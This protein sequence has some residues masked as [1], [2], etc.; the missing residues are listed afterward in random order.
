MVVL[1]PIV[2]VA[3]GLTKGDWFAAFLFALSVAVGL[4]P[5]MLPMIINACLARGSAVMGQ[6]QT[7][8]KNINAMQSFGSM[9]VLCVDKTGTLTGDTVLLEYYMDI[10]GN[11]QAGPGLFLS[12][13]SVS[14]R[15]EKPFRSGNP[16]MQRNAGAKLLF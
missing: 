6:K 9:D 13:Q 12:E 15:R 2:F 3:C 14:Y 4:T 7:I 1:I 10:L 11:E 16:K 8:V 5:E